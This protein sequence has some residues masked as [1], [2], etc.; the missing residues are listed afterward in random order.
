[1]DAR[2]MELGSS[3]NCPVL[4]PKRLMPGE[5]RKRVERRNTSKD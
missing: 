2:R 1:M 4:R 5:G 3:L